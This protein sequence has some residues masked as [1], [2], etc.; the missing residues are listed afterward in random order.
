M[1]W[2]LSAVINEHI[3]II[4]IKEIACKS[5]NSCC[6]LWRVLILRQLCSC[7]ARGKENY[8]SYDADMWGQILINIIT[9][10]NSIV[11]TSMWTEFENRVT[12]PWKPTNTGKTEIEI[13][14][15]LSLKQKPWGFVFWTIL[16]HPFLFQ[17]IV[18][19]KNRV[20]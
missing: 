12:L 9:H 7:K 20:V 1:K 4:L 8:E 2:V 6:K 19:W 11:W 16:Q 13:K 14:K 10:W 18:G 15:Q 17:I 5:S 3:M